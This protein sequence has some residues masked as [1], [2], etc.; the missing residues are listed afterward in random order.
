[1]AQNRGQPS[2]GPCKALT[3]I[4]SKSLNKI[5]QR[6]GFHHPLDCLSI[7]NNCCDT[8]FLSALLTQPRGPRS[9]RGCGLPKVSC[10]IFQ[11][12]WGC[13]SCHGGVPKQH[14]MCAQAPESLLKCQP[15]L[16]ARHCK[17][18]PH[19]PSGIRLHCVLQ[20]PVSRNMHTQ[21]WRKKETL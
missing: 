13:L 14:M 10:H 19:F 4:S 18:S 9:P 3:L 1:M 15:P 21:G 7:R 16:E 5:S 11:P 12:F 20:E 8:D 17:N 2:H 6:G